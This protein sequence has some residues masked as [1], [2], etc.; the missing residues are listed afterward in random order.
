MANGG[1]QNMNSPTSRQ[2]PTA[3]AV[4]KALSRRTSEWL[5]YLTV[6]LTVIGMVVCMAV[7][8]S[9]SHADI[10][11]WTAEQDHVTKT[12]LK[13]V[14][15]EQYV[16]LHEFTQVKQSLTDLKEDSEKIENKLDRVLDKLN[17]PQRYRN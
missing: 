3:I 10:K 5:K 4:D 14:I 7:W 16:P 8:A 11:S 6:I 1:I 15:K 13:G 9:N 17:K 12:E 2:T